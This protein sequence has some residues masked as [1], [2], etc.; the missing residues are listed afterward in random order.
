MRNVSLALLCLFA[1]GVNG[2]PAGVQSRNECLSLRNQ[3]RM[4]DA[5][6]QL[7][8]AG[9]KR[10]H[11]TAGEIRAEEEKSQH[12]IATIRESILQAGGVEDLLFLFM[13]VYDRPYG[14]AKPDARILPQILNWTA[15][16]LTAARGIDPN[17]DVGWIAWGP[18]DSIVRTFTDLVGEDLIDR[19]RCYSGF[20]EALIQFID[21]DTERVSLEGN[22]AIRTLMLLNTPEGNKFLKELKAT[23]YSEYVPRSSDLEQRIK[24]R[25]ALARTKCPRERSRKHPA[26]LY[27]FQ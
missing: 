22:W 8:L 18:D 4:R 13:D 1:M 3:V 27:S 23:Y 5:F 14:L 21:R 11:P 10:V 15:G 2:Q 19:M 20:V 24:I 7:Y 17:H 12:A 25:L 16:L 6:N 9:P 26:V